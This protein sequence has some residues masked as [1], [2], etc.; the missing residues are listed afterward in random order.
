MDSTRPVEQ[1][2]IVTLS[3]VAK[4]LVEVPASKMPEIAAVARH[5]LAL[6]VTFGNSLSLHAE[7]MALLSQWIVLTENRASQ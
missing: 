2:D 6:I 5:P 3:V 4:A 7:P 1:Y